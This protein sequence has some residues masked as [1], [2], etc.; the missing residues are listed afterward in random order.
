MGIWQTNHR[1]DWTSP[2]VDA[3]IPMV[4]ESTNRGE[5]AY[6][7]YS[8]L[9]KERVI[10]LGTPIDDQIANLIVAQLLFLEHEDPDRDIWLY[11]NSPGGSITAGLAIYDTMQVIRPDVATVCVGMAGSM[12]TPILAG[13]AKGKRYSLPHSTIHMHPA[14]GGARGYAPD[15]EIMARELLREQ[16]LVRELLAKDTGQPLERIARDFDRD[17]FMDPQQAKEYGIID[18]ILTREDLPAA[19]ERR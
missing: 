15:V 19:S 1:I 10:L 2:R 3:L 17:L 18:E 4:V 13:G 16:Q 8:R 7:I 11:I 12:A 14:G 5:R 6:D 9:L